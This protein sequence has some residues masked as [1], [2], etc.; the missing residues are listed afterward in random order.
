[1]FIGLKK[2]KA[3]TTN[4]TGSTL[5]FGIIATF[6]LIL[7]TVYYLWFPFQGASAGINTASLSIGIPG[8]AC[9]AAISFMNLALMWLQV[10]AGSKSLKKTGSNLGKKPLIIVIVFSVLF[11]L[12]MVIFFGPVNNKTVGSAIA[13]IFII[14]IMAAYLIGSKDL[15]NALENNLKPGQ[16]RSPRVLRIIKTG[17][18]VAWCLISFVVFNLGY[19]VVFTLKNLAV[20]TDGDNKPAP[21]AALN[22]IH[23]IA[24][25]GLIMSINAGVVVEF[26]YLADATAKSRGVVV[27]AK[28]M[29]TATTS[30]NTTVS[31]AG[32]DKNSRGSKS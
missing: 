15:A 29:A 30:G 2:K 17:R 20:P 11:C 28:A 9:F 3:P 32:S 24:I 6:F 22:P 13:L 14:G 8:S 4:A 18:D 7:W 23:S 26:L 31:D 16:K 25:T 1:M 21:A 10:A 5:F 27:K 19:A 12:L